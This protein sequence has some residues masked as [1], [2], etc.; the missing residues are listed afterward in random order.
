MPN[1]FIQNY[2]NEL[3]VKRENSERELDSA[4]SMLNHWKE[5]KEA[6]EKRI[7]EIDEALIVLGYEGEES[8]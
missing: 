6:Q 3:L 1:K 2:T 5:A 4:T 7:D 8:E